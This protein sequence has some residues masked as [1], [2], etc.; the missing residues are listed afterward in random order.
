MEEF[1]VAKDLMGLSIGTHGSNIQDARKTKGVTSIE[2]DEHNS[3]FKICGETEQA[4]KQARS[5]LEYSE[6][7]ILVP[8]E[9]IGKMIGKNGANIQD[10]V[11]KSGVVRV[12]IEGDT[13][14][15]TPRD[16][17]NQVPFVFVGTVENIN[18]AKLLIE[19]QLESLK[20]LD[21][22]RK[23]KLQMDEQLRSLM[24]TSTS[25]YKGNNNTNGGNNSNNNNSSNSGSNNYYRGGSESRYNNG[26]SNSEERTF[27]YS[28]NYFFKTNTNRKPHN[29]GENPNYVHNNNNNNR[30]P[31]NYH[32][33][34]NNSNNIA[35]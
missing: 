17:S 13:E 1:V 19:Y 4:V 20:E 34:N 25:Y 24:N 27:A 11:D 14:T 31:N 28:N 10:M 29:T 6:E 33:N 18:N 8:R 3:K 5:M 16:I 32:Y 12:K 26:N 30:R 7:I 21:Q 15:T 9:Y 23:E 22:L 2:I 35:I